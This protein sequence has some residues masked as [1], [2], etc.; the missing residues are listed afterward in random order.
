MNTYLS[1]IDKY[2]F[3]FQ[4]DNAMI[5]IIKDQERIF[6]WQHEKKKA[7][8]EHNLPLSWADI[9]L[10]FS[11]PF[12]FVLRDLVQF[13]NGRLSGYCRVLSEADLNGG[14]GVVV[15]PVYED[16]VLLIHQYRHPTRMWHYEVP[17]GYGES[18]LS[19][20]EN[21]YKEVEEETGGKISELINLGELH[22]DSGFDG[23][24]A[25]LYYAKLNSFGQ[26]NEDEG[27]DSITWVT[28]QELEEWIADDKI[29]DGFTIAAFTRARLKG[30]I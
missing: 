5:K 27:I 6:S 18:N 11:D 12:F 15:L 14:R 3:L 21:A 30:L 7:L 4:N 19:P 26:A 25:L 2:P 9:G 24:S 10:V 8:I 29:T 17:R 13:P 16:K 23:N 22:M 20:E 1:L 28:V